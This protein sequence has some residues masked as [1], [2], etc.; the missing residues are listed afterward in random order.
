MLQIRPTFSVQDKSRTGLAEQEKSRGAAVA[1]V[2]APCQWSALCS[3]PHIPQYAGS[4]SRATRP[5]CCFCEQYV[6]CLLEFLFRP[7]PKIRR[8]RHFRDMQQCYIWQPLHPS[9]EVE[10]SRRGSK[11]RRC[12]SS[13]H[14]EPEG[15]LSIVKAGPR[16][17]SRSHYVVAATCSHFLT[18]VPQANAAPSRGANPRQRHLQHY[19]HSNCSP[20]REEKKNKTKLLFL[21]TVTHRLSR[22]H[23]TWPARQRPGPARPA[24]RRSGS[25]TPR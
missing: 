18:R 1:K 7:N 10:H 22:T 15:R 13:C 25:R 12:R 20:L 4:Y 17:G 14:V 23:Q 8:T 5:N 2:L 3:C 16:W 19:C 9:G 21:I 6:T 11:G 24:R